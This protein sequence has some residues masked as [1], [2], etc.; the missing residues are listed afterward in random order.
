MGKGGP[1]DAQRGECYRARLGRLAVT[2]AG[3]RAGFIAAARRAV[4]AARAGLGAVLQGH[5][6]AARAEGAALCR[7][8]R[9]QRLGLHRDAR[10]TPGRWA[11]LVGTRREPDRDLAGTVDHS[12]HAGL[13]R[14]PGSTAGCEL[15]TER[16]CLR[17][18]ADR[19]DRDALEPP[20]WGIRN[21][22]RR[23]RAPG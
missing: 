14:G 3:D 22:A 10:P 4:R 20:G 18:A 13:L 2:R 11:R 8:L 23:R 15:S 16:L 5:L 9:L 7:R 19:D 12:R 6:G 17:L 21:V 1:Q